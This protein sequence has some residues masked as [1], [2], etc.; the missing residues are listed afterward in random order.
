MTTTARDLLIA[1]SLKYKGDWDK[2]MNAISKRE[3][4]GEEFIEQA[5]HLKC[6]AITLLDDKYP[7]FLKSIM[8][9]PFVLF[10]YGDLNLIKDHNKN[11]AISGTRTP[12]DY[13][14]K[15]TVEIVSDL[16]AQD[17]TIVSGFSLGVNTVAHLTAVRDGGNTVA[18]LPCGIDFCFPLKN[19]KLY[20]DMKRSQLI[21]SEY[22]G[23]TP[24]VVESNPFRNRIIAGLSRA[25]VII[26]AKRQSSSMTMAF[27]ALQFG[28]DVM[29]L[30]Q[31][32][33][34]ESGCNLLIKEGAALIENAQDIIDQLS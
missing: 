22:P 5:V 1:T 33:S 10:Y 6:K 30:P 7:S 23:D 28:A 4:P 19:E 16:A 12:S 13:S 24:P 2:I 11:I 20:E 27:F 17:Y 29:C 31:P 32:A 8:K 18:V 34:G 14:S 21:I 26:E 25:L 3:N 9:P 15:K